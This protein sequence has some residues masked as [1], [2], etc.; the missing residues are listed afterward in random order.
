MD[1]VRHHHAVSHK[2][3]RKAAEPWIMLLFLSPYSPDFNPIEQI[4]RRTQSVATHNKYFPSID[5]M[6]A[7]DWNIFDE[8]QYNNDTI[9]FCA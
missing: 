3:W 8:W 5:D 7:S 1:N 6:S 2:E 4:W 9:S